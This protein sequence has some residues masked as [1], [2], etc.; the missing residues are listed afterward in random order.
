MKARCVC[1]SRPVARAWLSVTV[2]LLGG[3]GEELW[4]WP[5]HVFAV[6]PSQTFQDFADAI[7]GAFA[8]WDRSHL[9][10]FTLSD[11]RI[12]TDRET[13][14]EMAT[15][16]GGPVVK[17]VDIATARVARTVE[18]GAEFQFTFDLGDDWTHRCVVARKRLTRSTC[19]ATS[20]TIRCPTGAGAA[21]PDQY[22]RRW[23]DDDGRDN[24]P[25][26]PTQPHPMLR[27][28]WPL[29]ERLGAVDLEE[30]RAAI[31]AHRLGTVLS[32]P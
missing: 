7:N 28:E 21:S 6:G 31:T 12:V 29:Q 11:G 17:A 1:D 13:G 27:Q 14:A 23:A 19:S 4:P 9:S 16:V 22:G 2:E 18:L 24:P 8:R 20:Q 32:P 25:R 15:S 5:G 30:L 10:M 3:R 26:R